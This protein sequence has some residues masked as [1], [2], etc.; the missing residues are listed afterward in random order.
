M[1]DTKKRSGRKQDRREMHNLHQ[2]QCT[3]IMNMHIDGSLNH[4]FKNSNRAIMQISTQTQRQKC[5]TGVRCVMCHRGLIPLEMKNWDNMTQ[6][7]NTSEGWWKY[8]LK[9]VIS[10]PHTL[11]LQTQPYLSLMK[12]ILSMSARFRLQAKNVKVQ[13]SESYCW[14]WGTLPFIYSYKYTHRVHKTEPNY[15]F[16][17]QCITNK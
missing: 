6:R 3:V 17:V 10:N 14:P 16:E 9:L 12:V 7:G 5:F 11:V 13:C 15:V 2:P 4:V 1:A 8:G